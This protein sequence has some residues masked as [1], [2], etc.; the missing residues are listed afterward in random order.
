MKYYAIK[1]GF[2]N[3]NKSVVEDKVVNTWAECERMVKGVKGAKY[4]SFTSINGAEEYLQGDS[5]ALKTSSYKFEKDIHYAYV[6]GSFNSSSFEYGYAFVVVCNDVVEHIENGGGKYDSKNSIRQIAGE[7]KAAVKAAE[8]AKTKALSKLIIVHDYVGVC[9][10]ATGQWERKDESSKKYYERIN[11]IINSSNLELKFLKVDS[12]TGDLFNEVVDEFAKSAA[13]VHI[14]GETE[15]ILKTKK[16]LVKN[17]DIKVKF[18]EILSPSIE[19]E[20][21][22]VKE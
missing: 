22:I 8:Y 9:Y 11:E 19:K 7:L 16:I 5:G 1:Y 20:A 13:N 14:K 2:D 18:S 4:K 21:I 15:K 17:D 10:H 12:H 3:V 6:D